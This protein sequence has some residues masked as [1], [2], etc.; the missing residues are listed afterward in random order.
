MAATSNPTTYADIKKIGM[1]V[2]GLV[3]TTA[4][5]A[6]GDVATAAAKG[7]AVFRIEP[8]FLRFSLYLIDGSLSHYLLAQIRLGVDKNV[9]KQA[10]KVAVKITAKSTAKNPSSSRLK[11]RLRRR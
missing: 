4:T 3:L 10:A 1:G 9:A 7:T 11:M 2:G 8:L 5:R 6:A